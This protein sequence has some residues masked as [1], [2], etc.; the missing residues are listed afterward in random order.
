MF[1][2]F[3][4]LGARGEFTP[5][6]MAATAAQYGSTISMEWVP[7]LIARYGLTPMG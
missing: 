6:T 2:K 4:Q 1:A 3:G 5:E 7:E